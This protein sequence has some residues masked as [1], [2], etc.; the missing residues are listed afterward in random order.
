MDRGLTAAPRADRLTLVR[1]AYL[2]LLGLP[3]T[4]AQV[5]EF[6]AD[7][8]PQA[9]ERLVDTLL[10][11]PHYGE[12]YGRHWLDVARYADSGGFEYDVHRPNAWRYRD[13]VIKSFNDDKPYNVFLTEQIAGDEID[14]KTDQT[15]IATGFLRMGPRVLFREKDNPER[16]FDYLDEIIGTIGKGTLG[17]TVNCARC[18]NHK[19]DPI[20]AKDYYSLQS[21]LFGY[22]E[23]EVPLAPRAD[24]EA[25]LAKN[26]EINGKACCVEDGD[27][28]AGEAAARPPGTRTDSD[29]VPAAHLPRGGEARE[30]SDARGKTSGHPGLRSRE[31]PGGAGREGIVARRPRE[32]AGHASP[33]RGARQAA[34]REVA[35]GRDCHRRRPS[36]FAA[37]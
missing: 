33:D 12:R 31:R 34:A 19:F 3:P 32:E 24:A 26:D 10:A 22:V 5:A 6:M 8:T 14:W 18:H 21:S 11:S 28:G 29:Q 15:L 17:L 2:D 30:G 4:P 1:R 25:Y 13:Y 9:W 20:S 36:V 7:Q 16:R 27:H 23:T 35:D 37:R